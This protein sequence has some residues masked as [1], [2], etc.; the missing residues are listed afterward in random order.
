LHISSTDTS[1]EALWQRLPA[2][3]LACLRFSR[4]LGQGSFGT[5]VLAEKRSDVDPERELW[6]DNCDI[7]GNELR[8]EDGTKLVA[9]KMIKPRA[10]EE[11][12]AMR[13]GL[14][15]ATIATV[16]KSALIPKCLDYGMHNG[17]VYIVLEYFDGVPLN[18]VLAREGP[19]CVQETAR[20]GC[21][22]AEALSAIHRAGFIHRD[23]KPHNILRCNRGH[24]TLYCLIDFG[25]AVGMEGCLFGA[26]SGSA[27]G[28]RQMVQDDDMY[29]AMIDALLFDSEVS[30]AE[31]EGCRLVVNPK[32]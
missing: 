20:V 8:C 24:E 19:L 16:E 23:I 26:V 30:L 27:E 9:V 25:S 10:G 1:P 15:L 5:V 28:R 32:P 31:D 11:A 4:V 2:D 14:V 21:H 12:L 22:M 17:I 29:G 3:L 18:E 6:T 13:E 7:T